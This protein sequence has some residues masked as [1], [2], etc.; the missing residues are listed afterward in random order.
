MS[1]LLHTR[2]VKTHSQRGAADFRLDTDA[3]FAAGVTTIFGPSGSGKSTWLECIAGLQ[4][5]D[6]G[7]ILFGGETLF[8]SERNI[9]LAPARRGI[10]YIFQNAALFPHLSVR[11]NVEYGLHALPASERRDEAQCSMD[12]FHIGHLAEK[13]AQ[14]ISGGERQRVALARA[15]VRGPNCL[16][17]DEP[18]S[19]LDHDTK[20]KIMEDVLAWN[21]DWRIP[22]LLVTHALEEVLAMARN[23]VVLEQGR[24][25]AEGEPETVLAPQR[26]RLL[27]SLAA[28]PGHADDLLS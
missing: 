17:L 13:N 24:V 15:L 6:S 28:S 4:R 12:A 10:G 22:I 7:K 27:A 14:A 23:V 20:L 21:R 9:H 2:I 1:G 8:D 16:L 19:A 26:E 3:R 25:V 18:F 11:A 5:P